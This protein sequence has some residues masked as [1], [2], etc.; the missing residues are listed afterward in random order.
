MRIQAMSLL[1]ATVV[2]SA[3]GGG[4]GSSSGG[5][6]DPSGGGSGLCAE[7]ASSASNCT[8]LLTNAQAEQASRVNTFNQAIKSLAE[9]TAT[10]CDNTA[11]DSALTA[12]KDSFATATIAWQQLEPM[13]F[14]VI[15]ESIRND[16]YSWPL[17]V[18]KE[19]Q[20][21]AE[22]AAVANTGQFTPSPVRR[23][24]TATEYIL[25]NNPADAARCDYVKR[26]TARME[27][28]A[29]TLDTAVAAYNPAQISNKE[30]EVQ[31]VFNALFY[32]DTETKS[33]KTQE[34][35]L[36]EDDAGTFDAGKLEYQYA[37][38]N[39]AAVE[40]NLEGAM[41]IF[42]GNNGIGF[43]QLLV[44][45]PRGT[46][47]MA[48]EMKDALQVA[49]DGAKEGEFSENWRTIINNAGSADVQ[50]CVNAPVVIAS[51]S[52][53]LQKLCSLPKKMQEFTGDLKNS[54]SIALSLSVPGGAESDG[55]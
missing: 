26:V 1:A 41:A 16:F 40:A 17:S 33:A 27:G 34:G 32:L 29:A 53:D 31:A 9:T 46:S 7:V 43:E 10:Y 39:R 42:S 18:G 13:Q 5:S 4:G 22:I 11:S 3:C 23:G 25:Y 47:A 44:A 6:G 45:S 28:E 8:A 15:S 21:D 35:I 38:L 20:I 36:P 50:A 48:N 24:L 2:L 14:G 12:A 37:D 52:T 30:A 55:D 51:D 49:I 19:G 54:A